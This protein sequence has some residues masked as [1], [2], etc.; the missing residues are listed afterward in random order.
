MKFW[1]MAILGFNFNIYFGQTLAPGSSLCNTLTTK[2]HVWT[3][4]SI[5]V[6]FMV[7][8][9]WEHNLSVGSYGTFKMPPQ[10]VENETPSPP[11][12]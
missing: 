2:L 3:E 10:R 8:L 11:P 9:I 4:S 5:I 12:L 7:K 1:K 6:E